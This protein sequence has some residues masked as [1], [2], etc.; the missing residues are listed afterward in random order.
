MWGLLVIL[1]FILVLS[2]RLRHRRVATTR[3]LKTRRIIA[4]FP[5]V[6]GM[7]GRPSVI[8]PNKKVMRITLGGAGMRLRREK[9]ASLKKLQ[10]MDHIIKVPVQ[11]ARENPESLSALNVSPDVRAVTLDFGTR[12]MILHDKEKHDGVQ[13]S[14]T[15]DKNGGIHFKPLRGEN[16]SRLGT[17][18]MNLDTPHSEGG[19]GKVRCGNACFDVQSSTMPSHRTVLGW[20]D[21]EAGKHRFVFNL[22]SQ[23]AVVQ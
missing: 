4:V 8:L 23:T 12:Q 13:F 22:K 18:G 14:Y 10:L 9:A 7:G 20:R 15:H 1:V 17:V 6:G 3:A 5:M 19:Y 21:V 16:W 2:I 11:L